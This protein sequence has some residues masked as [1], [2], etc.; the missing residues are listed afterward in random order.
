MNS[1]TEDTTI[2]VA[3]VNGGADLSLPA[4]DVAIYYPD[5]LDSAHRAKVTP[6]LL[7][8]GFVHAQKIFA[9]AGVQL[10]LDSFKTGSLDPA[11]FGV[12]STKPGSEIPSG[13]Y[14]NMYVEAERRPAVISA[15]ANLAFKT[16]V[17]NAPGNDLKA[18]LVILQDVF[19]EFYEQLDFRTWQLKTIS[20][21]GLSFPGY[22]YGATMPRHLRGVITITDLAKENTSWKTIAHELGHKLLNVSHEYAT[23]SPQHEVRADGGLMLYGVGTEILSGAEGRYHHERLHRSPY[24]YRTAPDGSRRYNPDYGGGGFYYDQI[25]DGISVDLDAEAAAS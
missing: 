8:E 11:L 17:G 1:W 12:N 15:D 10:I 7:V 2:D 22:M 9:D 4:V 25:Y 14:A 23:T 6:E 16:I 19:M 24:L 3:E 21:G 20:T 18:H 13:R 5:N